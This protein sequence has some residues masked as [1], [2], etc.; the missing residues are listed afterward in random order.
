[1]LGSRARRIEFADRDQW[2]STTPEALAAYEDFLAR[3]IGA[4]AA[5][6]RILGGEPTVTGGSQA[7]VYLWARSESLLNVAF[8]SSPVTMLCPCHTSQTEADVLGLARTTHPHVLQRGALAP[9]EQYAEPSA[10]VLEH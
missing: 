5:W 1:M 9:S 8:R 4:G 6:I 2:Y 10:F 7:D 3:A